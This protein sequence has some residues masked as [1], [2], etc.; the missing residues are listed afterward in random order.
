MTPNSV[1]RAKAREQL[2]GGIFKS[3]W[4]MALVICLLNS[5]L[6]S[7]AS[8]FLGILGFMMEGFL[9]FGLAYVF[10]S[11]VRGQKATVEIGDMFAGGKNLGSVIVLG[12]IKNIFI[13]LWSLLFVIP[14]I[15]KSYSYAMTYYIRYDHPEYDWKACITES[16]KM[17]KGHKWR[18]FCLDFSFIGW[19]IVGSLL[20]GIG[21]LWVAPYAQAAR[22]NFYD[23]LKAHYEPAPIV[24]EAPVAEAAAEEKPEA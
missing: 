3:N 24:E 17:M 18:L 19:Y 23:D 16:R 11:L 21:L 12:L 5:V 22:A 1:F 7:V 8:S 15:V 10:L 2:G 9:A 6:I 14:G 13:A 20:C 4:L